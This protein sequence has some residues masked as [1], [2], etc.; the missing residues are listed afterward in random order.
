MSM[1][2]LENVFEDDLELD[3]VEP[4]APV[5]DDAIYSNDENIFEPTSENNG[6]EELSIIDEFLALNGISNGTIKF[7][8]DDNKETEKNFYEL[9]KEEQLEVLNSF[10]QNPEQ[11]DTAEQ[12]FLEYLKSNNLSVNDFLTQYKDEVV[13]ELTAQYEPNYEIDAYDDEELFLLDLKSK[14][15]LTDEELKAELEKEL[16][17]DVLFK[18]KVD[19]LRSEYKKLEDQ[20]KETQQAEFNKQREEEYNKFADTIVDVAIKNSDF[21]GIELEDSEKNEVL[22]FLLDLDDNGTSEFYKELNKPDRLYEAAWFLKYG[23]SAFD[24]LRSAYES[25]ITKIKK[26]NTRPVVIKKDNQKN[27]NSIHDLHF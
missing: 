22:S 21:Y 25:E 18:K 2:E 11:P 5:P 3:A 10:M 15:D 4:D 24:A 13:K 12:Q 20:Y 17:N 27:P 8:D 23:K 9:T 14:Y 26:D 16:Q 19:S 6:Q 7:I 1:D